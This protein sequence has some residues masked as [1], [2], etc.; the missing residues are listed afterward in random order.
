MSAIFRLLSLVTFP[1]V[2]K[3]LPLRA[4]AARLRIEPFTAET[5]HQ[6]FGILTDGEAKDVMPFV[7]LDY[8]VTARREREASAEGVD[9]F[10]VA[11]GIA[12]RRKNDLMG[13]LPVNRGG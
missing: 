7:I 1:S 13:I 2:P 10:V 3:Q 4:S 5:R 12:A 11:A 6:L 9:G 8:R